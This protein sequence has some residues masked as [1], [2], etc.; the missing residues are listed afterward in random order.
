MRCP[1]S[2][3]ER[4]TL[5][6]AAR[7]FASVL[8]DDSRRPS[9]QRRPVTATLLSQ[10]RRRPPGR[11]ATTRIARSRRGTEGLRRHAPE[12]RPQVS[13]VCR[14]MR[15]RPIVELVL[16]RDIGRVEE[17]AATRNRRCVGK[18]ETSATKVV[19]RATSLRT[20]AA[21]MFGLWGRI[22]IGS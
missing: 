11:P 21:P 3:V 19:R 12:T 2:M 13:V 9:D 22:V 1:R 4:I 7:T 15:T 5:V 17:Y 8:S 18:S 6:P 16:S 14:R 10:P 20:P